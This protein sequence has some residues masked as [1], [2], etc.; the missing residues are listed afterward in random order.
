VEQGSAFEGLVDFA[1]ETA[2]VGFDS[3]GKDI[4]IEIPNVADEFV[5][6]DDAASVAHEVFEQS[7][8]SFSELDAF[9]A[10]ANIEIGGIKGEVADFE[11]IVGSVGGTAEQG[12]DAC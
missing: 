1:T 10:A 6:A 8:F 11:D 12:T 5:F 3:V 4:G 2:D 7:V 9:F